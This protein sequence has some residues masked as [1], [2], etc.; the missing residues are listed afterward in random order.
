[1]LSSSALKS[2]YNHTLTVLHCIIYSDNWLQIFCCLLVSW[3]EAEN[4]C[5]TL[6]GH[7][8]SFKEEK[9]LNDLALHVLNDRC[10]YWTGLIY[11]NSS[12]S[13]SDGE[14]NQYAITNF[15]HLRRKP[16]RNGEFVLV[17]KSGTPRPN[18]SIQLCTTFHNFI[19]QFP[20]RNDFTSLAGSSSSKYILL[21]I[22]LNPIY[23]ITL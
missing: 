19:C 6:C 5:K 23:T 1:M 4:H 11:V 2:L 12:W 13:F 14:D 9:D 7:L 10:L 16:K 17:E 21:F 3:Q 8:F 15:T 18:L 20:G 22:L